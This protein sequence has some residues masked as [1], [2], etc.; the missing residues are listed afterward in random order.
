MMADLADFDSIYNHFILRTG[1]MAG[2]LAKVFN[3]PEGD[4]DPKKVEDL[5]FSILAGT[6]AIQLFQDFVGLDELKERYA[7]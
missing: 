1:A 5:F 7:G 2:H 3:L 6:S 4:L